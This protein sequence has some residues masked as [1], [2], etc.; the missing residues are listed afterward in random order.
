MSLS[1]TM[2]AFAFV[3]SLAFAPSDEQASD[4]LARDGALKRCSLETP[5]MARTE[6]RCGSVIVGTA[7]DGARLAIH[8]AILPATGT[9][10][11]PD[12]IV[13]LPGGP[14]QASTELAG[15]AALAF[16][17]ARRDR[18]VVLFDPRGT[19]RSMKLSCDDRRTL[20]EKLR[21]SEQED[22]ALLEECA[23]RLPLDPKDVTT[24]HIA[25][26]LDAVRTALG[27]ATWN[28]VGVSY[29]TRLALAYD[30]AFPGKARTLILDGVV[31]FSMRVGEHAAADAARALDAL[32][33]RDASRHGARAGRTLTEITRNLRG[34]L[35]QAPVEVAL[36]HPTTGEALTL[37]LDGDAAAGVVRM[38]VYSEESAAILPPLLRA[39]ERG[40]LAPLAAQLVLGEK[41]EHTMSQPMH[42]SVLCA[43]DIAEVPG[44]AAG[45]ADDGTSPVFPDFQADMRRTCAHWP[46]ATVDS[47]FH[48]DEPASPTPALL[49]SGSADPVTPPAY[50]EAARRTLPNSVH[51]TAQ[52][53]GHNVMFRGCVP[54][55]VARFLKTPEPAALDVSC[56]AKLGPFP[57]FVDGLGPAP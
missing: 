14:G 18:D 41:L 28:L 4:A 51:V 52:G 36:A 5:G 37:P 21:A 24:A 7:R 16:A 3:S 49:L 17:K 15:I 44:G 53:L 27:V 13:L 25:R 54:D 48:D 35:E 45:A 47:A 23:R 39:A 34:K 57:V 19:G 30:R 20:A 40:E 43:E 46:H 33:A 8:F 10:K 32:S 2:T 12:P 29:G 56:A 11:H 6:A 55:V 31:P 38:L 1:T 9:N 42:L 22:A 26:D 50:A